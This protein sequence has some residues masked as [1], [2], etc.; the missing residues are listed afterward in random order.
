MVWAVRG[1]VAGSG[2]PTSEMRLV[3]VNI[4][5]EAQIEYPTVTPTLFVDELSEE[6]DGDDDILD[7]LVQ[8]INADGMEVSATKSLVSS[9]HPNLG[10]ALEDRLAP[11]L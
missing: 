10:R 4:V 7:N 8:R 6:L 5:D 2:G 3:M 11:L 9:P 1:I